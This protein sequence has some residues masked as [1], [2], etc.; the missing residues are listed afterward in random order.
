MTQAFADHTSFLHELLQQ[1][2]CALR[3]GRRADAR[4]CFQEAVAANPLDG[5][6][7]LQLARLSSPVARAFYLV[8]AFD[9]NPTNASVLDELR[10]AYH[11]VVRLATGPAPPAQPTIERVQDKP[12]A[13]VT[14][15]LPQ[16]VRLYTPPSVR[17]WL[18]AVFLGSGLMATLANAR[19]WQRPAPVAVGFAQASKVTL[20]P[21]ATGLP[22]L[23]PTPTFVNTATPIPSAT[24]TQFETWWSAALQ[25]D[26]WG[27]EKG[28]CPGPFSGPTSA[29]RF[30]W[31]A[32]NHYLSGHDFNL[33]THP[34]IDI[35][36]DMGAPIYAADAGVVVFDGWSSQGYGN[37]IVI[38]HGNG[39]ETAYA[40]LSQFNVDCGQG[41]AQGAVLGWAGSTGNS[42]GPHLHFEIINDQL[43]RVNPW[44]YLP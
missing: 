20:T 17:L 43:G 15:S 18:M 11:F 39:W 2:Q 6:A 35:A 1:G 8:E 22:T 14:L 42:T 34:G 23:T 38:D 9:L 28:A 32:D 5:E 12:P 36:A 19:G 33:R 16:P 29:A 21:T 26:G 31:P 30:A 24:P 44:S 41:V 25:R 40:H 27:Y 13:P 7:W 37:F 4:R 10:C 3:E